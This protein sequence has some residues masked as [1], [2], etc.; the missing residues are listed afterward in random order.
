MFSRLKLNRREMLNKNG[1]KINPCGTTEIISSLTYWLYHYFCL[2][3]NFEVSH[4]LA[5]S[6]SRS[7]SNFF[8]FAFLL[9]RKDALGTRLALK[10]KV[11]G[12]KYLILRLTNHNIYSRMLYEYEQSSKDFTVISYIFPVFK[13]Q[14]ETVLGTE[15]FLIYFQYFFQNISQVVFSYFFQKSLKL[16]TR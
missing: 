13:Q 9:Q 12:H 15:T 2:V 10:L 14:N 1:S 8:F 16:Q 6:Q 3:Y 4:A 7:Q 11:A 5:L